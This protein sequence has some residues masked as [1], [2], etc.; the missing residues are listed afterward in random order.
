M[1][2]MSS[3]PILHDVGGPLEQQDLERIARKALKELG[4]TPPS[5]TIVQASGQP[6]VWR[7]EFG[8]S[9]ALKITCGEGSSP[10]WVR[11]QIFDQFHSQ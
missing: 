4:V 7:I 5:L 2:G 8:G 11:E 10:Q 3:H 1:R 9:R 6:G